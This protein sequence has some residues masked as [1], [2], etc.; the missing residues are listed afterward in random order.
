MRAARLLLAAGLSI[1][2]GVAVAA[3]GDDLCKRDL[4][5]ADAALQA[6]FRR[7]EDV[8]SNEADRCRVWRQH[9]DTMR[10][11]SGT[12]ERCATGATRSEKLAQTSGSVAD[13]QRLIGER[14]K[15]K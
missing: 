9:V 11:A 8:G 3:P 2:S 14:C 7:L 4:F 5:M 1:G 6:S 10:K 15:G 12:F 13:F